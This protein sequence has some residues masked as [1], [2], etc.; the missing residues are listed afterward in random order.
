MLPSFIMPERMDIAM[1]LE[2]LKMN[3]LLGISNMKRKC[4]LYRYFCKLT[5]DK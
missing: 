2:K 3:H 5:Y 4:C 1:E